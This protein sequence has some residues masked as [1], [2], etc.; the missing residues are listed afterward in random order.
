MSE[1]IS[2]GTVRGFVKC[3]R[4]FRLSFS[5]AQSAAL[6]ADHRLSLLGVLQTIAGLW[7]H[8]MI[9]EYGSVKKLHEY[10][11]KKR[12]TIA[13]VKAEQISCA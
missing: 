13:A 8:A 10:L 9:Q 4:D 12:S 7:A 2:T 11:D 3:M 1:E 5:V 6:N